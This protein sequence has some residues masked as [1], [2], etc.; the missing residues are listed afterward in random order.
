MKRVTTLLLLSIVS[1]RSNDTGNSLKYYQYIKQGSIDFHE[2]PQSCA[3]LLN[4][5]PLNTRV[6]EEKDDSIPQEFIEKIKYFEGFSPSVYVCCGNA[7]TLGYGSTDK[8]FL[9]RKSVSKKEAE[10]YLKEK[11]LPECMNK[12]KEIV[13]VPLNEGQLLAL[14]SFTMNAGE[15]ALRNLV[16]GKNRL[17]NGNYKNTAKVLLEYVRAGGKVRK[18]LVKRRQWEYQIFKS[19]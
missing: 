15:G 12:V 9:K 14:T 3:P 5:V 10:E 1:L 16:N 19:N 11:E 2:V 7:K 4:L 8:T 18:G 13:K 17:N 6:E